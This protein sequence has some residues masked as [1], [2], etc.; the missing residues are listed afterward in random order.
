MIRKRLIIIGILFL[1]TAVF[2]RYPGAPKTAA[3]YDT[4][5]LVNGGFDRL[6]EDGLPEG[7]YTESYL[8]FSDI[9]LYD[10]MEG[11]VGTAARIINHAPNDAR[12]AQTVNVWPDTVYRLTGRILSNAHG[13]RGANLSIADIYVFSESVYQSDGVWQAVEIYGQTGPKQRSVTVFA[14]L[15]GYSGE[16][17]G[18]ACFDSVSLMAVE[19]VPDQA[20]V[21]SWEKQEAAVQ[22]GPAD[23]N[24]RSPFAPWLFMICL[25]A[26]YVMLKLARAA[27]N[28]DNLVQVSSDK[29]QYYGALLLVLLIALLIR[30]AVAVFAPGFPVDLSAFRAW[31][32]DMAQYGPRQFYL[33]E[34]HRDYPPGY[35][36]LLW[37]LGLLGK[38]SGS[39]ASELMV[40]LP[41]VLFDLCI[42]F[43]LYRVAWMSGARGKSALL[44]SLLYAINPLTILVGAAWGQV[45]SL[46]SLLLILSVMFI[47]RGRWRFALPVYVLA[48]LM[49][50]QALMVGPL[51]LVALVTQFLWDK[52]NL[53]KMLRDLLIGVVAGLLLALAVALPFFNEQ[54]GISWLIGLYGQTM[55]Y[56]HQA[57]VNATNLYYLFGLN[58]VDIQSAAPFMLR[59]VGGLT[60][61]L[62]GLAFAIRQARDKQQEQGARVFALAG[63]IVSALPV[64]LLAIPF[65]LAAFGI[66]MMGVVIIVVALQYI[67]ARDTGNLAFFGGLLLLGLSLLGT[68][69]HER[70]L[71][72]SMALLTLAYILKRDRR[73]LLLMLG[74]NLLCFLNTGLVLDLCLRNGDGT[75]YL[76]APAFGIHSQTAWLEYSLAFLSLP[77]MGY[78]IYL[79]YSL[80]GEKTV[81]RDVSPSRPALQCLSLPL[82]VLIKRRPKVTFDRRDALIILLFTLLYAVVAFINLGSTVSP[83][84]AWSSRPDTEEVRLDLGEQRQFRLLFFAGIHWADSDFTVSVSPDGETY[85]NYPF[86]ITQGGLFA[87]RYLSFPYQNTRGETEYD[88]NPRELCGRYIRISGISNKLTLMEVIAQ[89]SQTGENLPFLSASPGAHALIDEQDT[90]SGRPTWFNSMY[91]DEI[92]HARTALEQR[93][94]LWGEEPSSIYETS[95]PPL[96]KLLMTF[97]IMIFGMT[98][99]GWRFA[100]ALAGALMLPGMYLLG[101]QLTGRRWM[102]LLSLLLMAFDFM[103]FTQTRIATIDSFVTLFIIY[104][105]FFM[106]RYIM[107]DPIRTRLFNKLL[108]LF[109]SGLM[110]G[111]AIASKWPGIYAGGGLAILFF[112]SLISNTLIARRINTASDAELAVPPEDL[113]CVR[114]F[115]EQWLMEPILTCTWCL[116]F[117]VAIPAA[118]Y[119]LSYIPV[120]IATPGGL[121]FEKVRMNN[122]GMLD[123]HSVRGRGADHPWSSPWYSWPIIKKPMYFYSGGIRNGTASVIWSFGNPLVWWGGLLALVMTFVAAVREHLVPI[124]NIDI[125]PD[126]NLME[127]MQGRDRRPMI[128]LISF[129]VQYLPWALVPR[130]TYIYHYFPAVPFIILCKTLMTNYVMARNKKAGV[131]IVIVLSALAGALF[132]AF[133]PYISGVR[134][135]TAWLDAMR[136]LPN[137]L[138][139]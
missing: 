120:Y 89:D 31:A 109:F 25:L 122:L 71:F 48:V 21:C 35:M 78:G 62:P 76:S 42:V 12:F 108:P 133:F 115:G 118:I 98:P 119:Y 107:Q 33:Q 103:H 92:Y 131:W 116:L 8:G 97:S 40:K 22:P 47:M 135:S 83:Q 24:E 60:V 130:G 90:F 9:T 39:D 132:V 49:K 69:M 105:Y 53:G 17:E 110:M 6:G 15:G 134:V 50:P 127:M 13:G 46:P 37:P 102:G 136:W 29:R 111:L 138:F 61:L 66:L 30:F 85:Q 129:A 93:N 43:L 128:L 121:T 104:A 99:F 100:G 1:A 95:H 59:L 106:F 124:R 10:V 75:V 88:S 45:D 19:E 5:L 3:V 126:N 114:A 117:F 125:K 55:G 58:W 137:W 101:K 72:L 38:L 73:V 63:L 94:A 14:R 70:Y 27:R 44:L 68:M 56:Y 79:G 64:L 123:Y 34:G 57:T 112:S 16:A 41:S 65:S 74:V 18:E 26:T 52:D 32:N 77:L 87:W 81:V 28:A 82:K 139:Y 11:E 23:P 2:I 96:G 84:N 91:F 4:E 86:R 113:A 51:G 20:V 54:N 80:H 67:R 36:L 7:W